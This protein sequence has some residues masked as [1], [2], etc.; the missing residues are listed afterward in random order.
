MYSNK[1][2]FQKKPM[3]TYIVGV[4]PQPSLLAFHICLN[5]KTIQWFQ[6]LLARKDSFQ[7]AGEWEIYI[8]DQSINSIQQVE[9]YIKQNQPPSQPYKVEF[10][11]EQQRGRVKTIPEACLVTAAKAKGWG[12]NIPHPATWKKGIS[13]PIKDNTTGNKANKLVAVQLKEEELIEW[14]KNNNTKVPKTTH[15]LCDAACITT[16]GHTLVCSRNKI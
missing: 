11:C 15:H 8:S 6:V 2:D 4:D 7:T 1:R 12:V 14:C 13:F 9:N 3:T 5:E 10:F 16:Y